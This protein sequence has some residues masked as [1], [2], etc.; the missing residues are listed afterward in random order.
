MPGCSTAF[1]RT[2]ARRSPHE[3]LDGPQSVVWQQAANRMHATRAVLAT[4]L[5]EA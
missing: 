5:E 4:L 3:V 2:G 1:P